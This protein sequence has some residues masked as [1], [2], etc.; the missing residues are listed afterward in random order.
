MGRQKLY[1]VPLL[2]GIKPEDMR[3][4]DGV[5]NALSCETEEQLIQLV[6]D[7]GKELSIAPQSTTAYLSQVRKVKALAELPSPHQSSVPV[8]KRQ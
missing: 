5:L 8:P 6:E 3:G 4:P 1:M 7:I 2:A